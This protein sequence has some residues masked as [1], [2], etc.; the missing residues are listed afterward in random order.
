[1]VEEHRVERQPPPA[2]VTEVQRAHHVSPD[3]ARPE[4]VE[5]HPDEVEARVLDEGTVEGHGATEDGPLVR[6]QHL[7]ADVEQERGSEETRS[8]P[9]EGAPE[10]VAIDVDQD[11]EGDRQAHGDA[12]RSPHG[13]AESH[14]GILDI[15]IAF[16][17]PAVDGHVTP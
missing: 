16:A 6:A 3:R 12:E 7:T 15:E 13:G 9:G 8:D 17:N 5:E 2:A 4:Q 14:G 11:V 10:I 1:A